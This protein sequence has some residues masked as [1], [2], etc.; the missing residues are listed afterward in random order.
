[1]K[2]KKKL[3]RLLQKELASVMTEDSLKAAVIQ[4]IIYEC[5]KESIKLHDQSIKR[6]F[7]VFFQC[8]CVSGAVSKLVLC[9]DTHAFYDEHYAEIEEM[10]EQEEES[11]GQPI[12]VVRD[13]KNFFAWFAFEKT[14][15]DVATEIGLSF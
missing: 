12:K 6:F 9:K 5:K 3:N 7:D 15:L 10:R 2:L 14:A 13:L 8:G 1:M 4:I 11:I